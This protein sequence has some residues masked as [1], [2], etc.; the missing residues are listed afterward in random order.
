MSMRP[1][2]PVLESH[3]VLPGAVYLQVSPGGRKRARD[4]PPAP[5]RASHLQDRAS[6]Q[7]G[8]SPGEAVL[9]AA[10]FSALCNESPCVDACLVAPKAVFSLFQK[11]R[12]A[13]NVATVWLGVR[14]SGFGLWQ[15]RE[16]GGQFAR[17]PWAVG[18]ATL[19]LLP[20]QPK[21]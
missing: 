17:A 14:A 12:C 9:Q 6:H 8:P 15:G 1:L 21:P 16:P 19:V 11:V 2:C 10:G 20:A 4:C 5:H 7:P 3:L 13:N 18:P